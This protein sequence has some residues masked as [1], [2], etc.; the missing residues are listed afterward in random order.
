MS[1][2]GHGHFIIPLK[3]Y[4]GTFIALLI[5][6]VITVLASRVDLGIL[7]TPMA[8]G[9]A[10]LKMSLVSA[11]FMGLRWEK[12]ISLVMF[13]GAFVAVAIFFLLTFSDFAF[14]GS[15]TPE[16]SEV[17]GFKTPVHLLEPGTDTHH[18]DGSAH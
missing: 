1:D 8:L 5:L 11:F 9:I 4:V 16:E 2:S 15:I 10:I 14:R 13:I 17:F 18:S 6:T 3:Y 7:N 12:E